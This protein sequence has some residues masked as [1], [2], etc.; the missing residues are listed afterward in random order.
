MDGWVGEYKSRFKDCLQQ[1]NYCTL[2]IDVVS[3]SDL[4]NLVYYILGSEI[5]TSSHFKLTR[6]VQM[7]N[8]LIFQI[9]SEI[10]KT[11]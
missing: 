11:I 2:G 6:Y 4:L 8:E 9:S 5:Q 10:W 3:L 7:L 1:K